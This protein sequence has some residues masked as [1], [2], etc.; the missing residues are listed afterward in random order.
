MTGGPKALGKH[1]ADARAQARERAR[2]G[3]GRMGRNAEQEGFGLLL[4]FLLI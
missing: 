1:A 2:S 4:L 3:L